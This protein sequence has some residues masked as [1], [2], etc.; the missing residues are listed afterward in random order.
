MRNVAADN[1]RAWI[2]EEPNAVRVRYSGGVQNYLGEY[3]SRDEEREDVALA[4]FKVS[5]RRKKTPAGDRSSDKWRAGFVDD[6]LRKGDRIEWKG[7][8]F[9]VMNVL[10]F[11]LDG[12]VAFRRADLEVRE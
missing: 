10:P 12:E 3:D 1:V 8:I 7:M 2:P 6:I 9:E 4:V 11:E 5:G